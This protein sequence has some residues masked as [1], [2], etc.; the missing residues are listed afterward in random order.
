MYEIKEDASDVYVDYTTQEAKDEVAA[1]LEQDDRVDNYVLGTMSS[2][3]CLDWDKYSCSNQITACVFD[4]YSCM[5]LPV[6][7]G[8]NPESYDE[9]ALSAKV[10]EDMDKEA[11][12]IV[13]V[14]AIGA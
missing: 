1:Y 11:F 8:R 9:V 12:I 6:I 7:Q 5:E 2:T 13:L 3:V 10:A 14:F 4:D